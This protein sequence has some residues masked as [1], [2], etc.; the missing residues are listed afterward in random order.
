MMRPEPI[1]D[2]ASRERIV[3]ARDPL[4]KRLATSGR[5]GSSSWRG[6]LKWMFGIVEDGRNSGSDWISGPCPLPAVQDL[7]RRRGRV[8]IVER[9]DFVVRDTLL[10]FRSPCFRSEERRVG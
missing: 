9:A 7:G 5:G 3:G 6:N 4:G 8:L 10:L 2:D 1:D